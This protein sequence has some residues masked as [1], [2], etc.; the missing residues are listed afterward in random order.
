MCKHMQ[1]YI[2]K[3]PGDDSGNDVEAGTGIDALQNALCMEVMRK[4]KG[5][6][7][8]AT[9][10]MNTRTG[11]EVSGLAKALH[12]QIERLSTKVA[13]RIAEIIDR[14]PEQTPNPELISTKIEQ[15]LAT[16]EKFL[17]QDGIGDMVRGIIAD[18]IQSEIHKKLGKFAAGLSQKMALISQYE[19]AV[20]S[21][22][23]D[24]SAEARQRMEKLS[25]AKNLASRAIADVLNQ[26]T[27]YDLPTGHMKL[28]KMILLALERSSVELMQ[29]AKE[30]EYVLDELKKLKEGGFTKETWKV[31]VCVCLCI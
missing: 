1:S 29:D 19:K 24:L 27:K 7:E 14:T 3:A 17:F 31:C 16:F 13:P 10:Q 5:K 12:A 9:K 20:A 15:T 6:V 11:K 2:D 22:T 4:V 25:C 8:E 28:F 21:S 18:Q 26:S 23:K 30:I